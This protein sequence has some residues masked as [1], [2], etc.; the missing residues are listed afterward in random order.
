MSR[1]KRLDYALL[2]AGGASVCVLLRGDVII[3]AGISYGKQCRDKN[4]LE[5]EITCKFEFGP[6]QSLY[7]EAY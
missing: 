2:H 3:G 6:N 1:R 5:K 7:N 4:E